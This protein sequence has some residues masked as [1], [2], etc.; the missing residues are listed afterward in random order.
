MSAAQSLFQP[1]LFEENWRMA[2]KF[3]VISGKILALCSEKKRMV[4]LTGLNLRMT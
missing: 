2:K 3:A 4:P 1:D